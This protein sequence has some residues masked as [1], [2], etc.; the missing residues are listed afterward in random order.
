MNPPLQPGALLQVPKLAGLVQHAF[1]YVGPVG[2]NGEDV[3]NNTPERGVHLAHLKQE[4]AGRAA[5]L[6]APAPPDWRE[7]NSMVQRALN[8][9][10][11]PWRLFGNNCEDTANYIR[12]GRASSPQ[13]E[14]WIGLFIVLGL[15]CLLARR[16]R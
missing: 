7:Q 9:L 4:I 13:L 6:V 5:R 16:S 12:T 11:R 15:I 2:P 10:G 14:F 3:V 1:T 8:Q